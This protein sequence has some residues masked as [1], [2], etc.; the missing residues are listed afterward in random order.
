VNDDPAGA[1]DKHSA[2]FDAIRDADQ[3]LDDALGHVRAEAAAG[4]ITAAEAADERAT[5]LERHLELCRQ[6]RRD[7]L[8]G[9]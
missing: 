6:L 3:A 8:G 5:L 1:G 7:H 9:S 2:Y 4:R